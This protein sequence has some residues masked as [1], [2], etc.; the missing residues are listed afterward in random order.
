MDRATSALALTVLATA[1]V[2]GIGHAPLWSV[3]VCA[4]MLALV[5]LSRPRTSISEAGAGLLEPASVV[6]SVVN[7]SVMAPA[8][9]VLGYAA[10]WAWGF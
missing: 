4:S 1:C 9:Y 3:A 5:G 6:V 2:G 8:S 7:A 10:R